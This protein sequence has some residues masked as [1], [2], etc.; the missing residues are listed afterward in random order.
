VRSTASRTY[1]RLLER[2]LEP[3]PER[4]QRETARVVS[5]DDAT[6]RAFLR[7]SIDGLYDAAPDLSCKDTTTPGQR[8]LGLGLGTALV[9]LLLLETHA[10]LMAIIAVLTY[11]Y[12]VVVIYRVRLFRRSMLSDSLLDISDEEALALEDLPIIT[13]LIPAY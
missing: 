5:L 9:M 6:S 3:R 13:V 1:E 7:R 4:P 2:A 12:A 8:R 10:T 11:L